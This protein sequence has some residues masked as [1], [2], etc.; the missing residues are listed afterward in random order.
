MYT[1]CLNEIKLNDT[2]KTAE[3]TTTSAHIIPTTMRYVCVVS[4]WCLNGE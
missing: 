3:I 1:E 2:L 4:V